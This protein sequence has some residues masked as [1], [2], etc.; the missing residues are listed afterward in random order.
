MLSLGLRASLLTLALLA[1]SFVFAADL[2]LS[3]LI[4]VTIMLIAISLVL[5]REGR[6]S[7]APGAPG[8]GEPA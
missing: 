3:A 6:E 8:E 4:L 1:A 7:A 2:L 5:G